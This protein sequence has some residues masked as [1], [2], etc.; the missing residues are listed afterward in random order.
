MFFA[1]FTMLSP[2]NHVDTHL[3]MTSTTNL[4]SLPRELL[5]EIFG[6]LLEPA[7]SML[8]L[9]LAPN[10]FLTDSPN[11]T[12]KNISLVCRRLRQSVLPRLFEHLR[13]KIGLKALCYTFGPP[14]KGYD[15]ILGSDIHKREK[16][17]EKG[18]PEDFHRL[19]DFLMVTGLAKRVRSLT[20]ITLRKPTCF[21]DLRKTSRAPHFWADPIS[22][23]SFNRL[24]IAGNFST[25]G[26]L[27]GNKNCDEE[28]LEINARY[29]LVSLYRA[30]KAGQESHLPTL[31]SCPLSQA[32]ANFD[33]VIVNEG[34]QE[35]TTFDR[36]SYL[37]TLF[38][39]LS[40]EE[41]EW[42]K[43]LPTIVKWDFFRKIKSTRSF[44][45]IAACLP[46]YHVA[47]VVE[48]IIPHTSHICLRFLPHKE[49][50]Q[51]WGTTS[52]TD[53]DILERHY[54]VGVYRAIFKYAQLL[55]RPNNLFLHLEKILM[56]D[57][58]LKIEGQYWREMIAA[59]R[60]S[61]D[62]DDSWE[63]E[64]AGHEFGSLVK[65]SRASLPEA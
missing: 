40:E 13:F 15:C 59:L 27:F 51:R 52:G 48:E 41:E 11:P 1:Q 14:P 7:P 10:E 61:G 37:F 17:V 50:L 31:G 28:D 12:L 33:H 23:P 4:A 6:Y 64:E 8:R 16:K 20:L 58:C 34:L 36:S 35:G 56:I 49:D 47:G 25:L 65:K 53:K 46:A 39:L 21:L 30:A 9:D 19:V 60:D 62:I 32:A 2:H 38:H 44:T 18:W 57:D 54:M 3:S 24:T 26:Q 43:Q 29:Q 45:Y 5:D 63:D 22:F 42:T 55:P